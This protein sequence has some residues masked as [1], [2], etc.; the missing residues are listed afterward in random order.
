[1]QRGQRQFGGDGQQHQ[2]VAAAGVAQLD[3]GDF[4]VFHVDG[5]LVEVA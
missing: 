5:E 1:M 2:A 4:A 3:G